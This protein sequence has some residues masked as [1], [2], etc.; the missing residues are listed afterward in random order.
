MFCRLNVNL[1]NALN[2]L[3][4]TFYNEKKAAFRLV[5]TKI[6]KIRIGSTVY[7]KTVEVPDAKPS[8]KPAPEVKPPEPEKTLL[9]KAAEVVEE[10]VKPKARRGRKK[11]TSDAE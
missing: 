1:T 10:A 6:V 7:E 2:C 3:S 4:F 8:P 5:G 9:E 11:K